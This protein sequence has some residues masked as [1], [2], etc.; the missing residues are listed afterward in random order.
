MPRPQPGTY[1]PAFQGYIDQAAG[2]DCKTVLQDSYAGFE[3]FLKSLPD[4]KVNY[5]YAEGKW[6]IGQL[7]QHM[8]DTERIMLYRALCIARGETQSLPGFDE[9]AYADYA[10]ATHRSLASLVAES[11]TLRQSSIQMF[12]SF[13]EDDLQRLGS[14]N[15]HPLNANALGFIIAGHAVHHIKVMKERY[16]L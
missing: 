10:P 9:N 16:G 2:N 5:A 1:N 13:T 3:A 8:I 7:L 11:L 14:S 12:D 4:A 6:T 15:K